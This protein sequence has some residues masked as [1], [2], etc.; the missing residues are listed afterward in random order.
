[1]G[2]TRPGRSAKLSRRLYALARIRESIQTWKNATDDVAITSL[3]SGKDLDRVENGG[4]SLQGLRKRKI[5]QAER[6]LDTLQTK[7]H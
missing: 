1:M 2:H 6:E 3:L 4:E 7:A 5:H